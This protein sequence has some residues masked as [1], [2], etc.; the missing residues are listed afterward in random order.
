MSLRRFYSSPCL[1]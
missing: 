1:F